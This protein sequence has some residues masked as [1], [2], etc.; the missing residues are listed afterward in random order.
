MLRLH[1]EMDIYERRALALETEQRQ[2][3]AAGGSQ[4]EFW[5][6]R[7][8]QAQIFL[9]LRYRRLSATWEENAESSQKT[10]VI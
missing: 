3:F 1:D 10:Q 5:D 2:R 8:E 7:Y 4:T 9:I 6:S